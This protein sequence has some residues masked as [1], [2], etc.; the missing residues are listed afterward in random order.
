LD[1]QPEN[2]GNPSAATSKKPQPTPTDRPKR[3]RIFSFLLTFIACFAT[4][5]IL[6]GK[7]DIFHLSLGILASCIVALVSGDLLFSAENI[8]KLPRRSLGFIR[9][10]PWII[11]QIFLANIH[12]LKLVFHPKMREMI[13]P[14]IIYFRSHLDDEMA[15]FIFANSITLT[16]GTITVYVSIDGY[17]SVHAID[18]KSGQPLPGEMETR[19]ARI[20]SK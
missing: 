19:I 9:Y 17:F 7:F 20:F 11:Y 3:K 16:P 8:S 12:L 5:I 2:K 4:W 1:N 14:K 10:L 13:D 15:Y 18:K 6:S